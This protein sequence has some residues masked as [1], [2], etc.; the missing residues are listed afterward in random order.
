MK[1]WALIALAFSLAVAIFISTVP[2][3]R[4]AALEEKQ[5]YSMGLATE[6]RLF[7]FSESE[8][9]EKEEMISAP[10]EGTQ[11]SLFIREGS[12]TVREEDLGEELG[13]GI[14]RKLG[15][16]EEPDYKAFAFLDRISPASEPL[17]DLEFCYVVARIISSPDFPVPIDGKMEEI[18]FRREKGVLWASVEA[19]ICFSRFAEAYRIEW[20]PECARFSLCMPLEVKNSEISVDFDKI[21][22][23]CD[24][25]ELP[26]TALYFCCNVAFGKKDYKSLFTRSV[27][28]IF[29]NA[30]IYR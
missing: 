5:C 7:T 23:R 27:S 22:L 18:S 9:E 17:N 1:G 15:Q 2:S 28:N 3:A 20:L 4:I 26:E 19:T 11:D 8:K 12:L 14:K 13:E 29:V 16:E 30:G 21:I 24:S 10:E 25:V 6:E